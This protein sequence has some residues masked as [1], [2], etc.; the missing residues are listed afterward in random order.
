MYDIAREDGS[1]LVLAKSKARV[2][3]AILA[4]C[5]GFAPAM[6]QDAAPVI[7]TAPTP[8]VSPGQ[9]V[10]WL[11]VFK[12]NGAI[13]PSDPASDRACP[14]GGTPNTTYS[15]FSQN[16]AWASSADPELQ[17]GSGLVGA[18]DDPLG[19]T[20]SEIYRSNYH[21]VVWNDQF[22]DHP[23]IPGCCGSPW[24]HS[25]GMVAWNDAGEGIVLQVTTPAWPGAGS[26]TNARQ[27]DGNTLGCLAHNDVLYSQDF[28]SLKLSEPDLENV[29]D[30][31]ANASVGTDINNP[32]LVNDGGP[33]AIR[34]RVAKLG[35]RSTST[36]VLK[37]TL[38]SGIRLI[39]KPSR[40]A[41]PP[42]QLVSAE[43]G[44]INL[45]TATWWA[46]PKIPSTRVTTSIP[47]WSPGLLKPGAVQIAT[48]G[49]WGGRKIGLVGGPAPNANHAKIGVSTSGDAPLSIFGDMNQ[50]GALSGN[51]KSSQNGR[52]GLFFVVQDAVLHDS[53]R[54]LIAGTSAPF[55]LVA[56]KAKAKGKAPATRKHTRHAAISP[57]KQ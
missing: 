45:R 12:Q 13:F 30:A 46:A 4:V 2:I 57:T 9:S 33:E 16:Y 21:F 6:A 10:D 41:V 25:K 34:Q 43:L 37:F 52:G 18:G 36:S 44:G 51:C 3:T 56:K 54:D 11:F 53:V 47:C 23:D 31:L 48:S 29:L 38:S 8:L 32:T 24:G 19:A 40:L 17:Q 14:F 5:I 7:T 15:A 50:Q 55:T 49:E 27:G 35:V 22:E 39:S 1:M 28:F 42:W 26:S 20:F